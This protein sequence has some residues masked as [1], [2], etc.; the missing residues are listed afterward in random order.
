MKLDDFSFYFADSTKRVF[1]IS[2]QGGRGTSLIRF[3]LVDD[4]EHAKFCCNVNIQDGFP[5]HL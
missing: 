2:V 5:E 3:D 1:E 4:L